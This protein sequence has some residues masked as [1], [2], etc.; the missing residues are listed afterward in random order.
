MSISTFSTSFNYDFYTLQQSYPNHHPIVIHLFIY[1]LSFSVIKS[2]MQLRQST[3][4]DNER[5]NSVFSGLLKIFREEGVDGLYKGFVSK[6]V[7]SVLTAAFLFMYKE[8]LFKYTVIL[9]SLFSSPSS[10]NIT[11]TQKK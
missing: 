9:L 7:Q 11:T 3:K 4:D 8:A 6:V 1:C 10:R 5:Y 2:R